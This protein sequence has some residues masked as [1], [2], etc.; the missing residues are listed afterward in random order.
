[1]TLY[2]PQIIY[3]YL[4][5]LLCLCEYIPNNNNNNNTLSP[6]YFD[7]S[8]YDLSNTSQWITNIDS[9]EIISCTIDIPLLCI[10]KQKP[11]LMLFYNNKLY[12]FFNDLEWNKINIITDVSKDKN[13]DRRRLWGWGRKK[14]KRRTV[15]RRGA[16]GPR[17]PRG[18]R[19]HRGVRGVKGYRGHRGVRGHRGRRGIQ[20]RSGVSLFKGLFR[21]IKKA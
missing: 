11:L 19:G 9:N 3:I 14:K 17:G 13:S 7:I 2:F 16:R 21:G 1:M 15:V 12:D 6:I 18:S 8:H 10:Y 4:K 20:G 5:L